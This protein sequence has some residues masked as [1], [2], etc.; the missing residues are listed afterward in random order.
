MGAALR[1]LVTQSGHS[2]L[3]INV[4]VDDA[5]GEAGQD[6]RQG[7]PARSVPGHTRR[8]RDKRL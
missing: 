3:L 7:G 8:S 5:M 6:R 2:A 1:L 4:V